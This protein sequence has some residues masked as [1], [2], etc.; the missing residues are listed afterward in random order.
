M[1]V[2]TDTHKRLSMQSI[3]LFFS[4]SGGEIFL[5][6]L[7]VLIFF[8]ADKIPGMARTMGRTMR[9]IK[10]ATDEIQRD[11]QGSVKQ[12]KDQIEDVEKGPSGKTDSRKEDS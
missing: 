7:F 9:Q 11:I 1:Q 6:V 12:V 4:I 2:E 5:I 3:L 10:D 8:G